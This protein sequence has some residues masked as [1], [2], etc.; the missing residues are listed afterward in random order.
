MTIPQIK[1]FLGAIVRRKA[2]EGA[3]FVSNVAVGAQGDSKGIKKTVKN[4]LKIK[5]GKVDGR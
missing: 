2:V 5:S 3:N 4:Y 1:G